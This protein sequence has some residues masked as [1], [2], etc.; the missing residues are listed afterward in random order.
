VAP[1]VE[2]Y[3]ARGIAL[4]HEPGTPN[5]LAVLRQGMRDRLRTAPVCD[6]VGFARDMEVAYTGMFHR[7]DRP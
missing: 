6:A 7:G 1:D 3:V 4:A 5:R 2:G